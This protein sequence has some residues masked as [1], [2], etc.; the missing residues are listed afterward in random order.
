MRELYTPFGAHAY[1]VQYRV[2]GD[3]VV[4]LRIR[5]SLERR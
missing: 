2:Q 3:A 4:I 5:H 1:V